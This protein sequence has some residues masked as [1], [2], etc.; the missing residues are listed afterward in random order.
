MVCKNKSK[1]CLAFL[2]FELISKDE[3]ICDLGYPISYDK[4][5]NEFFCSNCKKFY[6]FMEDLI[7]R[8]KTEGRIK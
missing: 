7:N 8:K 6:S 5:K 3:P 2:S 4:E 1:E